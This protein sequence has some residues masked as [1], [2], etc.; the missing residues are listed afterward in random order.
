V[1]FPVF[2][3]KVTQVDEHVYK[4]FIVKVKPE[5][6]T[7]GFT[8]V[9][10][11]EFTGEYLNPNEFDDWMQ[12]K[13]DDFVLIDTRNDYE[14]RLGKFRGAL[15]LNSPNFRTFL[16]DVSNLD[17][18]IKEK[19]VITYCTGGIR[20]EKATAIMMK[21]LGF[22]KVMQ[23]EGGILNYLK[24]KSSKGFYEGDCFVF[25]ERVGINADLKRTQ[26]ILCNACRG[27][28]KPKD[29]EDERYVPNQSCPYCYE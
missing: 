22:K 21:K 11:D 25:D 8:D 26:A 16:K 29:L 15:D 3:W 24:E 4:R 6:V 17:E 1:G 2:E 5:I 20:C 10:P 13:H 19:A 7:T 27:P 18:S 23:L 9:R 14:I 12:G 28:L